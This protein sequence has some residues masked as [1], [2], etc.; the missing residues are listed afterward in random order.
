MPSNVP[1]PGPRP[2]RP[3]SSRVRPPPSSRVRPPPSS[4]VRPPRRRRPQPA[5]PTPGYGGPVQLRAE[6]SLVADRP[7][8]VVV[9]GRALSDEALDAAT[10]ALAAELAG[11]PVVGVDASPTLETVVAVLA[12]LRAGV[13]VV[14]LPPDAGPQELGH[15]LTDSGAAAL[16]VGADRREALAGVVAA[17]GCGGIV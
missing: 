16:L 14:P 4:R 10:A 15:V 2:R 7:D 1:A 9:A 13:P 6:P 17:A 11:A 12:A 5:G 3:A 8:A